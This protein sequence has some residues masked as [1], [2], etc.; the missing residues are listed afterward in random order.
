MAGN[1]IEGSQQQSAGIAI[2]T[3]NQD[4]KVPDGMHGPHHPEQSKGSIEIPNQ[5]QSSATNQQ[6]ENGVESDE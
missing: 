4:V 3:T 2:G 5:Q 1:K 6:R